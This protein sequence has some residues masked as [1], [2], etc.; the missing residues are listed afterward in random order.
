M[1]AERLASTAEKLGD[2]VSAV[3]L[4]HDSGPGQDQRE[5]NYLLLKDGAER[6]QSWS[7]ELLEQATAQSLH[8]A[9]MTHDIMITK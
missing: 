3:Q 1:L 5:R 6:L 2:C 7:A 8:P 4:D 9:G